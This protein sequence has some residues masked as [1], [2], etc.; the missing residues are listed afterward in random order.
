MIDEI[1]KLKSIPTS[2]SDSISELIIKDGGKCLAEEEMNELLKNC[3]SEEDFI[4]WLD[5]AF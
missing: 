1:N 5:N 3:I 2:N 4:K